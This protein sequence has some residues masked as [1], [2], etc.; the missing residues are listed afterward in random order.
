M[1]KHNNK[2]FTLVELLVVI[3]IIGLLSTLAVVSLSA[4]RNRARDAKRLADMSSIRSALELVASNNSLGF[5]PDVGAS[6]ILVSSKCVDNDSTIK[7]SCTSAA[8]TLLKIPSDT[9]S[10]ATNGFYY[11]STTNKLG[12]CV[13]F[14]PEANSKFKC[15][16]PSSVTDETDQATCMAKCP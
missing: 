15:G 9:V 12:Y 4:A 10:D 8:S 2:G 6:A 14:Q 5:Y 7:A 13:G 1:R 3:S 11:K 16:T